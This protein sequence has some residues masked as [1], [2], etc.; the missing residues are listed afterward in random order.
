M[1]QFMPI[2]IIYCGTRRTD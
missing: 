2:I 1:N